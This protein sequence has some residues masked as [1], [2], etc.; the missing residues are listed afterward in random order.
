[1]YRMVRNYTGL[2]FAELDELYCDDFLL[3][4]RNAI[5]ES[6]MQ[7][8]EGREILSEFKYSQLDGDE[9][10]DRLDRLIGL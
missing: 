2:S 5:V 1:M 7:S 6:L 8:K 9:A 3:F 4:Y 10:L